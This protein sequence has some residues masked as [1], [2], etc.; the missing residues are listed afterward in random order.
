MWALVNIGGGSPPPRPAARPLTSSLPVLSRIG[1]RLRAAKGLYKFFKILLLV[2]QAVCWRL[3][4]PKC[5]GKIV[6]FLI[7]LPGLAAD[8]LLA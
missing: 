7:D 2:V 8:A 4:R 1:D 6:I 5:A 3:E